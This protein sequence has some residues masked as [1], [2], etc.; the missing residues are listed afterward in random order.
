MPDARAER[1]AELFKSASECGSE[2]W[3]AF[4]DEKCRSDPAIRAEV[5]SLLKQ[6]A[7]QFMETPALHLA[8]EILIPD[9]GLKTGDTIGDYKIVSRLGEGG[10]GEVYLAQDIEL[11]RQVAIK[12]VRQGFGTKSILRHLRQEARILAG[13]ND[14]H[15]ARLYGAAV[16]AQGVPY[17]VME[18]VEGERLDRY[19]EAHC[20][21]IP[22]RLELFR[23]VCS[24]VTYTHQHLV[25]H[26][27]LKPA[28]IRVTRRANRSCSISASPNC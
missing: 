24:A 19:C 25:I 11:N 28:N 23:K 9:G 10:M 14:P 26:R 2:H 18:Y 6:D 1:V 15:I 16:T 5:E 3:S 21:T 7:S 12:L 17:F 4:L 13:L 22:E 20:L 27:D 8:A